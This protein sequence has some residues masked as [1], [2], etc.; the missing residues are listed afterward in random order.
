VPIVALDNGLVTSPKSPTSL[1]H[2]FAAREI[3][4][5]AKT[6]TVKTS[7]CIVLLAARSQS[8]KFFAVECDAVIRNA[9][10][11]SCDELLAVVCDSTMSR[12]IPVGMDGCGYLVTRC[13]YVTALM[14]APVCA[15]QFS[16]RRMAYRAL[17]A[18]ANMKFPLFIALLSICSSNLTSWI[19][20]CSAAKSCNA[21][22]A[23]DVSILY[24][25]LSIVLLRSLSAISSAWLQ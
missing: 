3:T 6:T 19:F 12:T 1:T 15:I 25:V 13:Q 5:N 21:W 14:S 22:Y 10:V 16:G 9:R 18:S 7:L 20:C 23:L 17:M 24:C 4:F 8:W 2:A 11:A